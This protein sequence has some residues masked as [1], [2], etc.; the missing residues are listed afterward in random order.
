MTRE[1]LDKIF[2]NEYVSWDGDNAL[3]GLKILE[4]YAN[5]DVL[6]GADH[7]VIYSIDVDEALENGLTNEDAESL[8]KMNWMIDEDFD[9]FACFV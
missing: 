3:Q 5:D 4:K 6:C 1:E 2:D 9:G 7:D 8:R